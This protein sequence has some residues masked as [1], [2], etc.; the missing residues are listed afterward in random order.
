MPDLLRPRL[1]TSTASLLP[2]S[3]GQ[4]MSRVKGREVES[5]SGW[6]KQQSHIG[7]Y[8]RLGEDIKAILTYLTMTKIMLRI[9]EDTSSEPH[10]P[11]SSSTINLCSPDKEIEA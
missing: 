8:T 10:N 7:I 3:I 1:R 5:T 6:E 4:R 11:E 2:H 9:H